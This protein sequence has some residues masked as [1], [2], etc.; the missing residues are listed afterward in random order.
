MNETQKRTTQQPKRDLTEAEEAKKQTRERE[1]LALERQKERDC[2]PSALNAYAA[3]R[4]DKAK[5]QTYQFLSTNFDKMTHAVT[6]TFNK[7]ELNNYLKFCDSATYT[8]AKHR[9][10]RESYQ[11]FLKRLNSYCLNTAYRKHGKRVPAVGVIEGLSNDSNPH[12]HCAM[13]KPKHMTDAAFAKTVRKCWR[14][15]AFAGM[16]VDVQQLNN[17]NGWA[18]YLSKTAT[19]VRKLTLDKDNIQ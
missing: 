13:L 11:V 1:R 18:S 16:Q 19:D 6:L 9:V 12:Y 5:E 7:H 8:E 4:Q 14:Q 17:A 3:L 15:V 10:I 2:N